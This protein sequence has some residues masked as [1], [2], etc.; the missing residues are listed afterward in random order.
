MA[1]TPNCVPYCVVWL[2][3]NAM[4]IGSAPSVG[5]KPAKVRVPRRGAVTMP[6]FEKRQ[7]LR[8]AGRLAVDGHIHRPNA[9]RRGLRKVKGGR[10]RVAER[11][12]HRRRRRLVVG[13]SDWSGR[14][15][16]V[17]GTVAFDGRFRVAVPAVV[18]TRGAL[19]GF[20]IEILQRAGIEAAVGERRI[21]LQ[22]SPVEVTTL[23]F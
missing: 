17:G 10:I 12:I 1:L 5:V 9:G 18:A 2:K 23:P 19:R 20:Q 3:L 7:G 13:S 14:R 15:A 8:R 4:V 16:S 22:E 11:V 6:V 21:H